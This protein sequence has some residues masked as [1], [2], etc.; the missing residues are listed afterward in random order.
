M[1][2]QSHASPNIDTPEPEQAAPPS[3]QRLARQGQQPAHP[4]TAHEGPGQRPGESAA[5]AASRRQADQH[6]NLERQSA[7]ALRA[8]PRDRVRDTYVRIFLGLFGLT[9]VC[10]LALVVYAVFE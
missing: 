9:M 4:Q 6:R 3:G 10:M 5:D 1:S 8:E 2:F 7:G